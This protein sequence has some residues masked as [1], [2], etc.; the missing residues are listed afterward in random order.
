MKANNYQLCKMLIALT[1]VLYLASKWNYSTFCINRID[2]KT[3]LGT[4]SP[5]PYPPAIN[6]IPNRTLLQVQVL[7]RHG[8]RYWTHSKHKKM[9]ELT[10]YFRSNVDPKKHPT[11]ANLILPYPENAAGQLTPLGKKQMYEFGERIKKSY[12]INF[13]KVYSSITV[14]I[15]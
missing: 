9:I 8:V 15:D 7:S 11:L 4:K 2:I 3:S 6:P 5:Y 13:P 1:A 14:R 12:K 10:S